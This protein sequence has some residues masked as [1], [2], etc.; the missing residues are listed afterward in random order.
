MHGYR[1]AIKCTF[2]VLSI[3]FL[4][5]GIAAANDRY[6]DANM[7]LFHILLT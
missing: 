4:T 6:I 7:I 1:S 2:H 5:K 3:H